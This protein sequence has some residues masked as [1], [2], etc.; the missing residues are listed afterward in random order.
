M[1]SCV[2]ITFLDYLRSKLGI[3]GENCE[4]VYSKQFDLNNDGD[5]SDDEIEKSAFMKFIFSDVEYREKLLSFRLKPAFNNALYEIAEYLSDGSLAP[6]A[7]PIFRSYFTYNLSKPLEIEFHDGLEKIYPQ[8]SLHQ[9]FARECAPYYVF[10]DLSTTSEHLDQCFRKK[11]G[12]GL[13]ESGTLNILNVLQ[14]RT[15][16]TR[17]DSGGELDEVVSAVNSAPGVSLSTRSATAGQSQSELT[18]KYIEEHARVGREKFGEAYRAIYGAPVLQDP[19]FVEK[20][21]VILIPNMHISSDYDPLRMTTPPAFRAVDGDKAK[22]AMTDLEG[23]TRAYFSKDFLD[24]YSLVK[25]FSNDIDSASGLLS[26]FHPEIKKGNFENAIYTRLAEELMALDFEDPW[27]D[28]NACVFSGCSLQD[29]FARELSGKRIGV[30]VGDDVMNLPWSIGS[31]IFMERSRQGFGPAQ[32]ILGLAMEAY[33]DPVV[34]DHFKGIFNEDDFMDEKNSLRNILEKPVMSYALCL[35]YVL[36]K[37]ERGPFANPSVRGLR[38]YYPFPSNAADAREHSLLARAEMLVAYPETSTHVQADIISEDHGFPMSC[39][40]GSL[41]GK[42]P[43]YPG[44][45]LFRDKQDVM[46]EDGNFLSLFNCAI[47]SS[48]AD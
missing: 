11:F 19:G 42:L 20:N 24:I 38:Q 22:Y 41:F 8:N 21:E 43:D 29:A 46:M 48:K 47:D 23:S 32:V 16:S 40:W 30:V 3:L 26:R 4:P 10:R 27:Q 18:E 15:I 2:K 45:R 31:A 33:A 28:L 36:L 17:S 35:D 44:L 5:L 9:L 37:L 7:V 12:N 39:M 6:V 14:G 1:G 34:K 25:H 13:V